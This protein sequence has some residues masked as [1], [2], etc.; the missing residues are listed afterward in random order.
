MV[1]LRGRG[2]SDLRSVSQLRAVGGAEVREYSTPA[3]NMGMKTLIGWMEKY[4]SRGAGG[5]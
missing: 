1:R 5:E 3:P 4:H 2:L